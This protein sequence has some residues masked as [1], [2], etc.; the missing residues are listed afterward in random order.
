MPK[1][2]CAKADEQNKEFVCMSPDEQ[3]ARPC[4][5]IIESV[6]I[7]TKNLTLLLVLALIALVNLYLANVTGISAYRTFHYNEASQNAYS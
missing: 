6:S 3:H 1:S 4:I 2:C 7:S 5:A